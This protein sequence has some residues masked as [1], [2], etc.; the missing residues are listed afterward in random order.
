MKRTILALAA[1]LSLAAGVATA[2]NAIEVGVGPR[3]VHVGPD[4]HHHRGYNSYNR[5]SDCR[6]VITKRV[7]RFGE[8]VTVRRRICD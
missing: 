6:V 4:R 7:N 1:G 8:R 5:S 2:A 3:G